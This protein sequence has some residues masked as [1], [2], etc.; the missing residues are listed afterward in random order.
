[1]TNLEPPS[2]K[3]LSGE[4]ISWTMDAQDLQVLVVVTNFSPGPVVR[5]ISTLS[6]YQ[7]KSSF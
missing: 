6:F 7:D 3:I 2:V 5:A 1:M 4:K